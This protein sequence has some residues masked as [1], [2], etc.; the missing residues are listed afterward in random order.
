MHNVCFRSGLP[1]LAVRAREHGLVN[2][3]PLTAVEDLGVMHTLVP[4]E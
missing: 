3:R 4:H 2:D 1:E